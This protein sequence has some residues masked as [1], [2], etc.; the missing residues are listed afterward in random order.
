M[1]SEISCNNSHIFC[2]CCPTTRRYSP[3]QIILRFFFFFL[4]DGHF[5]TKRHHSDHFLVDEKTATKPFSNETRFLNDQQSH[6][7]L[8]KFV[9]QNN[10]KLLRGMNCCHMKEGSLGAWI[11]TGCGEK[12]RRLQMILDYSENFFSGR[13]A[14]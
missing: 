14:H 8:F 12:E 9:S 5:S 3:F 1:A 2:I 6:T 13:S 11:K 4:T 10:C 7:A